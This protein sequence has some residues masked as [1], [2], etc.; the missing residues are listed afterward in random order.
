MSLLSLHGLSVTVGARQVCRDLDLRLEA[1]QSW[2]LLGA[3]G[4]GKTTLLHTL[5]GLRPPSAGE[6]RL[7][8]VPLHALPRRQLARQLGLLPQDSVDPMPATVLETALIGR[9]PHLGLWQ[10]ESPADLALARTALAAVELADAETR[11]V[12]TLSGGER[13]RLAL[14]TLLTQAPRIHLLD[15]PT[16][17]LDL[18]HQ[19]GLL[20]LLRERVRDQGGLLVMSLHDLNLAARFCDHLLLLFGDGEVLAGPAV[21]VLAPA[22]LQR[23]YGHP[24][25]VVESEGRRAFVPA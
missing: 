7:N 10:W 14:A 17:H 11:P 6:I 25:A 23:L 3:N 18:R 20:T 16:N 22:H 9:H 2:G 4:T 19:V 5:A 8:G 15:E 12:G 13:R 21:Q 24:I 1:G